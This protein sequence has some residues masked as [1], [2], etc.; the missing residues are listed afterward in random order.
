[1]GPVSVLDKDPS[2]LGL[3]EIMTLA[4]NCVQ[5]ESSSAQEVLWMLS[6]LRTSTQYPLQAPFWI[7]WSPLS[8]QR[9]SKRHWNSSLALGG[10]RA[11]GAGLRFHK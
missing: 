10:A 7:L 11:E 8:P 9:A 4:V 5:Q 6:Q 3:P 2:P 1:M